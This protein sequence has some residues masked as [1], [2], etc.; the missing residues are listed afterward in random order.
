M[1]SKRAAIKLK[2][3]ENDGVGKLPEYGA[4]FMSNSITKKECL[5]RKLFGLSSTHN[6][7]VKHIKVGMILFLFEYDRRELHGVFQACSD[8]GIDIVPHAFS[9]SGMHC[10]AQVRMECIC[11]IDYFWVFNEGW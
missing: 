8:G 9:K 4:I 6:G 11:F 10:P 3:M 7:F 2:E 5:R 1:F